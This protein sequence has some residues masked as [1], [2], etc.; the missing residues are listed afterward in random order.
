CTKEFT[1]VYNLKAHF[2][3]HSN[4]R[5]YQCQ[6]CSADFAR[7]RDQQRHERSVHGGKKEFVCEGCGGEFARR[8][9]LQRHLR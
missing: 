1:E 6:H 5:P 3:L 8:D 4:V 2:F 7:L 9:S